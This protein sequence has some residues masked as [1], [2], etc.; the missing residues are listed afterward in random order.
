MQWHQLVACPSQIFA[1]LF[2]RTVSVLLASSTRTSPGR[3]RTC[4]CQQ[5]PTGR[6]SPTGWWLG[7]S[8]GAHSRNRGKHVTA[9]FDSFAAGQWTIPPIFLDSSVPWVN[10]PKLRPILGMK[11]VLFNEHNVHCKTKAGPHTKLQK[12]FSCCSF[13]GGCR[14]RFHQVAGAIVGNNMNHDPAME[15]SS[16]G[17]SRSLLGGPTIMSPAA[18]PNLSRWPQPM[19]FGRCWLSPNGGPRRMGV[20][21]LWFRGKRLE[22]MCPDKG[23]SLPALLPA[24]PLQLSP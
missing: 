21:S 18:V 1:P 23:S 7:V 6:T 14:V 17:Q 10:A 12:L 13:G 9:C 15:L 5:R 24:F 8:C 11:G 3:R 19:S 16:T 2:A 4:Q 20:F 22:T